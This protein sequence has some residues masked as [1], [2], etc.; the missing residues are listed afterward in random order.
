MIIYEIRELIYT[1]TLLRIYAHTE[2][3][4]HKEE[5]YRVNSEWKL[6][7]DTDIKQALENEKSKFDMLLSKEREI[8]KLEKA[9]IVNDIMSER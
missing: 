3:E 6:K 4:R 1:H 5:I 9:K 7:Y 2:R 8:N